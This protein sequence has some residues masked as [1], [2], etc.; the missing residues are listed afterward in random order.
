MI[1]YVTSRR[2]NNLESYTISRLSR[3]YS[4]VLIAL[5]LT[6]LF[7]QIGSLA[8]PEF[9]SFH[10]VLTKPES[11][12]GYLSSFFFVNEYRIFH[13]NGIAPGTNG[14]YWSLSF[15]ATY[16]FIA[17]ILLFTR[18]W[19]WLPVAVLLLISA[20]NTIA[21]LMPLWFMGFYLYRLKIDFIRQSY[22]TYFIFFGSIIAL[23]LAPVVDNYLPHINHYIRFPWGRGPFNRDVVVDYYIAAAFC[24][25]II[26]GRVIF[27]E[28][29]N[30]F[31]KVEKIIRWLGQLTFPLYLIHFP[32]LCLFSAISPFSNKSIANLAFVT[33]STFAVVVIFTPLTNT[34][35]NYLR[36]NI[37]IKELMHPK[38]LSVL[39][40]TAKPNPL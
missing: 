11:W 37:K 12:Q 13:F 34:L 21:I 3:L 25:N 30:L 33:T 38:L 39:K 32:S 8:N 6:F 10:K 31:K 28:S 5:P 22:K 26:Y 15:E 16:Y 4:V 7:D 35:K 19:F 1:S 24:M 2:E 27:N 29:L 23:L 17:G 36:R 18:K 9:Y 20:G 40:Y 14:P